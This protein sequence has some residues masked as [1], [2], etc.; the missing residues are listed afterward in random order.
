MITG[1]CRQQGLVFLRRF[2]IPELGFMYGDMMTSIRSM[3]NSILNAADRIFR[4]EVAYAHCDVPCGI[5]DP[6]AAQLSAHTVIRMD[7]L[8]ADL[9]KQQ[10]PTAEDRNKMIRCVQVK[11]Q[12]AEICKSEVRIIWGDYFK[13]E[14]I[15]AN[16]E[17]NELVW[18]IMHAASKAKQT[19]DIKNGEELLA[20]V[21]RFAEIFWKTK[22]V[23]TKR[24]KSFYPTE[25]REMVFPKV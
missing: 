21:N 14:H 8:I 17:L 3:T 4:F 5:Y 6:H 16:P 18:N 9:S 12:H 13:P 19:V 24:A 25:E 20:N 15:K 11:E 10:N 7:M 22:G 2:F 1:L 23:E